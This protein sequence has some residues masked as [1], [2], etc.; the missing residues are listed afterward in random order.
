MIYSQATGRIDAMQKRY[1]DD[2]GGNLL[3]SWSCARKNIET[4]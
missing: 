3:L 2:M 1:V 4:L